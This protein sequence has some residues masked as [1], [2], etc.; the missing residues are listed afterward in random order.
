LLEEMLAI[1]TEHR[2]DLDPQIAVAM[3]QFTPLLVAITDDLAR[4]RRSGA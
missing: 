4:L 3:A 1:R 2:P